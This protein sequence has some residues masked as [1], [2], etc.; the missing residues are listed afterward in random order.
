MVLTCLGAVRRG[1]YELWKDCMK[2]TRLGQLD[3]SFKAK[4]RRKKR[5]DAEGTGK[6]TP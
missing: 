6:E 4:P 2:G 3:P 1:H 5:P